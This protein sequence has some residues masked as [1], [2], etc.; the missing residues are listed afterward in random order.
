LVKTLVAYLTDLSD[1]DRAYVNF[2]EGDEV[3]ILVNNLDGISVLETGA[4]TDEVL[5]QLPSH[6]SPI[7]VYTGMFEI[8]LHAPA[9]SLSICN[10]TATAKAVDLKVVQDLRISG[11]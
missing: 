11:C 9:F 10:L 7:R 4:L 3:A 8:S 6:I 1:K 2:E 5:N